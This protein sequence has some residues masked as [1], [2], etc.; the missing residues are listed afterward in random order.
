[1]QK[2]LFLLLVYKFKFL[3]KLNYFTTYSHFM[4]CKNVIE[5]IVTLKLYI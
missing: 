2:N 4:T 5:S 1:M 3:L